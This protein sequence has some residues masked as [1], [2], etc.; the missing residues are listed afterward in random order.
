M[1]VRKPPRRTL[2]ILLTAALTLAACN[3]G[4]APAPTSDIN[5][6]N[7]A[8]LATAMA[9]ISAQQTQTALVAAPTSTSLPTNTAIPLVTFAPSG[10]AAASP[11]GSGGALPTVSFNITP[12][13]TPLAGFTP[14]AS[15]A[16]PAATASLG[17]ACNNS[18]FEGDVTIPDGSVMKPGEDFI[19]TWKIRNTGSC[20]WDE[21]Y[22]LVFIGGDRA[23]D[24]Y[25]FKFKNGDDFVSPG[26]AID[27][28]IDLTAPL[29]EGKYQGTWRMQ[30]DQGYYFG[31]LVSVYFEVKK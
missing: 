23:I 30:N 21:G 4:A 26:E 25:D 28:S 8:A 1:L 13:T 27:I 24:P 19:K 6:I 18:A 17:D 10:Q 7:T 14:I 2:L 22:S 3:V 29:A 16:A 31:T 11:T 12:N 20:T 15:S 9:Q 5:A